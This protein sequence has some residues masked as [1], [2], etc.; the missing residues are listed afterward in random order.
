MRQLPQIG[1][2]LN[3]R[4]PSVHETRRIA[5]GAV[6]REDTPPANAV[7]GYIFL[8]RN[9]LSSEHLI[10]VRLEPLERLFSHDIQD[11]TSDD[12]LDGAL[13]SVRIILIHPN[14][15]KIAAAAS[16]WNADLFRH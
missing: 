4:E 10:E 8:A 5:R 3:E 13:Q 2:V 11:R 16:E 1:D 14:V 15:P 7:I 6:R 9:F 12:F